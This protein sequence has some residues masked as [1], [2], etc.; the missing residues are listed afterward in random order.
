MNLQEAQVK[1]G[2]C[3]A[4][5]GYDPVGTVQGRDMDRCTYRIMF[6]HQGKIL[7]V[8][9]EYS[10]FDDCIPEEDYITGE[11]RGLLKAVN[12]GLSE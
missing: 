12:R 4:K 10:W 7:G 8:S 5:M 3:I 2:W 6:T 9:V 1:L 11:M